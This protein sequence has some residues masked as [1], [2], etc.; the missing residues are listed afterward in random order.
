M[1]RLGASVG[2]YL[3]LIE[4]CRGAGPWDNDN[5]SI[6]DCKGMQG[7]AR[8][9]RDVFLMCGDDARNGQACPA[10]SLY[11]RTNHI[12]NSVNHETYSLWHRDFAILRENSRVL[13]NHWQHPI[14]MASDLSG[15]L[16]C[17]N[18]QWKYV[19][20]RGWK[21]RSLQ[22]INGD[23]FPRAEVNLVFTDSVSPSPTLAE[24]TVI[25][26][27][28]KGLR[29]LALLAQRRRD[30]IVELGNSNTFDSD[31][32]TYLKKFAAAA[33]S[34]K[35]DSSSFNS[36][37]FTENVPTM[38][39]KF[40]DALGKFPTKE[41]DFTTQDLMRSDKDNEQS[42]SNNLDWS[43][44]VAERL[45]ERVTI[46][47]PITFT[48]STSNLSGAKSLKV[49]AKSPKARGRGRRNIFG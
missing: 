29:D 16:E 49:T 8:I 30:V 32:E 11:V 14:T 45:S 41:L 33:Y 23:A 21:T 31:F 13:G 35:Q 18:G 17:Q 25:P 6:V 2:F 26:V 7:P 1:T 5:S 36:I 9:S 20:K 24:H 4:C 12:L 15:K 37:N 3:A 34:M 47:V 40:D 28:V 38:A 46:V 22:A 42:N 43:P 44:P 19:N 10:E 48:G 39:A 27:V